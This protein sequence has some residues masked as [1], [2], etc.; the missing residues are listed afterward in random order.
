MSRDELEE[1]LINARLNVDSPYNDGWTQDMFREK[2]I[3]LEDK[4]RRIGKQLTFDFGK[5]INNI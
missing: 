2:I 5:D 3:Y 4:L 1:E